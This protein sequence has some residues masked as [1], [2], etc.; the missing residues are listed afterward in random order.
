MEWMILIPAIALYYIFALITCELANL[1]LDNKYTYVV[2]LFWP[3]YWVV[4][5]II[6]AV[7]SLAVGLN[8]VLRRICRGWKRRGKRR[9]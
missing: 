9:K 8:M 1:P 4:F 7:C 2:G 3:I 5:L 6:I